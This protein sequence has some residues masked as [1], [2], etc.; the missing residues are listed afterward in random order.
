[1]RDDEAPPTERINRLLLFFFFSLFYFTLTPQ[2]NAATFTVEARFPNGGEGY[3][4]FK[5][6]VSCEN[7]DEYEYELTAASEET[8][9]YAD[10]ADIN[11]K[12]TAELTDVQD[13]IFTYHEGDSINRDNGWIHGVNTRDVPEG[14]FYLELQFPEIMTDNE[15][16]KVD[17]CEIDDYGL[18]RGFVW[19]DDNRNQFRSDGEDYLSDVSIELINEDGEIISRELST[20]E[21][22]IYTFKNLSPG[23]YFVSLENRKNYDITMSGKQDPLRVACG[24][25]VIT[26]PRF[27]VNPKPVIEDKLDEVPGAE[28]ATQLDHSKKDVVLEQSRNGEE[29]DNGEVGSR[30]VKSEGSVMILAWLPRQLFN[31]DP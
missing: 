31:L 9:E 3:G 25:K 13:T 28:V 15:Q 4:P 8:F 29:G 24:D 1:M 6:Y 27:G 21:E 11:C 7:G 26:G 19:R 23:V 22:G 5:A 12:L 18:I 30:K 16:S 17:E 20:E 14:T 2:V 10:N